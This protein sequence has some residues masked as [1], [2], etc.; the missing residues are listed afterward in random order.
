MGRHDFTPLYSKYAELIE[1][2]DE[3]FDSHT[4]ILALAKRNQREYVAA[5]SAYADGEPFLQVHSQ[6]SSRF[7]RI[8]DLV[9]KVGSVPS[10]DI[11]GKSNTCMQWRKR[12]K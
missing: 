7:D 10:K 12:R 6:L 3:V 9:E 5:L 11:F 8:P 1:Q 2:M 4:F